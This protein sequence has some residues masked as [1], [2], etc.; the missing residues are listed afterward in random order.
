M[1]R[2]SSMGMERNVSSEPINSIGLAA[3]LDV[4]VERHG[5]LAV[6]MDARGAHY[7]KLEGHWPVATV[8]RQRHEVAGLDLSAGR[9][10]AAQY[11]P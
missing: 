3:V 8:R 2:R 9:E 11:F 4:M 6:V 5:D 7:H 10:A 1:V